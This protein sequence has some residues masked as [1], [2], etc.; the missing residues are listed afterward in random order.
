MRKSAEIGMK[1]VG[2]TIRGTGV[3][4]SNENLYRMAREGKLPFVTDI[5]AG[6][7]G[8]TNIL[9]WRADFEKWAREYLRPYQEGGG[10]RC[11]GCGRRSQRTWPRTSRR[12]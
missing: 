8:R 5:S 2:Q 6:G 12:R 3:R 9:I 10:G 7:K 4:I 11:R 1:E